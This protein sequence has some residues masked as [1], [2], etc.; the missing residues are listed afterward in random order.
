MRQWS[1]LARHMLIPGCSRPQGVF[2]AEE[3]DVMKCELCNSDELEPR[4]RL[5]VPC[6]EAV[7]R[8][9]NIANNPTVSYA[10]QDEKVQAPVRI[11]R[12]PFVA[13]PPLADFL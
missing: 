6:K 7:A 3:E 8:L 11:K 9:W 5:C 4:Q 1:D 12:A 13:L 10:H 2:L